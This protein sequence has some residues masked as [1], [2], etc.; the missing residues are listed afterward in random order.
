M[1][2]IHFTGSADRTVKF[3]DLETFELIGSTRPEV[4]DIMCSLKWKLLSHF[5]YLGNSILCWVYPKMQKTCTRLPFLLFSMPAFILFYL[6]NF[7]ILG[8]GLHPISLTKLVTPLQSTGLR[9]ITFHPDGRTLFSGLEDS[10][11]VWIVI[12]M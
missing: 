6:F 10:M 2:M 4:S 9:A 1:D 5:N 12:V 8:Y 11:K 3:W 7:I